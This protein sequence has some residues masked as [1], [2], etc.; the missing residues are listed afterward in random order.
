MFTYR[1]IDKPLFAAGVTV[2]LHAPPARCASAA[3]GPSWRGYP[4]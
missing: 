1:N 2:P 3:S 4:I